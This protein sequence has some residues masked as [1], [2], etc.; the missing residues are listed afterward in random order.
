M[1]EY[2]PCPD[3]TEISIIIP[4]HNL[5]AYTKMCIESIGQHTPEK[6]EIIVVNNG[7]EDDT[8]LYLE[9][10]PHIHSIHNQENLG[11]AKAINQGLRIARGD[12]II[13]LNNDCIVSSEWTRSLLLAAQNVDVGIVGVMSNF[14]SRPQLINEKL[15]S[16][17]DI[18]Q[19]AQIMKKKY[20]HSLI[21]TIRVVG[22]CMLIK[23]ELIAKIGGFDPRFGLGNFEDD[24]FCLRSVL[25]GYKNVIAQ[26]V[27]IYHFG[28]MTFRHKKNL[29]NQLMKENWQ[30]FKEK[31][32]LPMELSLGT[33]D[34]LVRIIT[35]HLNEL[36]EKLYI[37]Y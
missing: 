23:R 3:V 6:H 18:P 27:F 5:A 36:A 21:N 32:E 31:W 13:V 29:R 10:N 17:A 12:F 28:S 25:A 19:I 16:L 30:K 34:Y 11:F 26:D 8:C 2:I 33:E 35:S 1:L 20:A 4:V 14:V 24:D 22:L 15:H 7:S 9:R 37:P